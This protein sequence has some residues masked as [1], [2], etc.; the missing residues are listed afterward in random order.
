MPKDESMGLE[1]RT[2]PVIEE[3]AV[4]NKRTVETGR[5]RII[6]SVETQDYLVSDSL[7]S[8]EVVVERVACGTE[9][10]PANLPQVRQ[11]GDVIIIPVIEE[12]LVV[13]KRLTL[14]EELH[15]QRVM[16]ETQHTVPVTLNR[17]KVTVERSHPGV[18]PSAKR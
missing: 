1:S 15:V 11:E 13:E 12:V 10:D 5:V 6:K 2:I 18:P 4:L 16:H 9:I 14:K 3:E 17:E 8:E 7:R